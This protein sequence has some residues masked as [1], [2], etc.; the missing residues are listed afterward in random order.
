MDREFSNA[1]AEMMSSRGPVQDEEYE[2]PPAVEHIKRAS[3]VSLF[4]FQE[5][6]VAQISRLAKSE[7][8]SRA[9][10]VSL[11]TG[12]GK[13]RTAAAACLRLFAGGH[14]R[15]VLWV[16]PTRE[17][18]EQAISAFK[19]LISLGEGPDAI[20]LA[21]LSQVHDTQS[22]GPTVFF[23]TCQLLASRTKGRG[24]LPTVELLIF[25][26]AHFALAPSYLEAVLFLLR[27]GVTVIGLTATPGR[28]DDHESERLAETFNNTWLISKLLGPRPMETLRERGVLSSVLFKQVE[29]AGA[30]PGTVVSRRHRKTLPI[31]AL[32]VHQGRFA[33]TVD[34]LLK[35]PSDERAIVFAGSLEH[36][37]G[38]AVAIRAKGRN[39]G[40]VSGYQDEGTRS[41]VLEDF[42]KGVIKIV[43]NKSVLI[44]GYD[45]PATK[46]VMIPI[47]VSSPI[48]FEQMVGRASRGP[49]VGGNTQSFVWV[50]DDLLVVHGSP[51]SY[52]RY[53]GNSWQGAS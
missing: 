47:P 31:E 34:A 9:A 27:S 6:L 12:A 38:L 40:L 14:V 24:G 46:H 30:G 33:A 8:K 41:K 25:D 15:K 23:A 44:A 43:L 45:C 1:V 20:A 18:L 49:L 7:S 10:L 3:A 37:A 17:L 22:D 21:R 26:E 32:C 2:T 52:A 29:F 35:I 53:Q 5:D 39:A 48:A 42:Q 13:T 51:S 11:P 36:A 50:L 19:L 16:A 4:D 28:A